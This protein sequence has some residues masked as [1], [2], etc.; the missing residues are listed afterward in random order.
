MEKLGE[1]VFSKFR[2]W[3]V[4]WVVAKSYHS[5]SCS[6]SCPS[7]AFVTFEVTLLNSR[8]T[9]QCE[10]ITYLAEPYVACY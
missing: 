6:I 2:I 3:N 7:E 10:F 8:Q 5:A 9:H 1:S 4:I